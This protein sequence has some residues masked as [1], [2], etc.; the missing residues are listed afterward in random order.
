MKNS[1]SWI[2]IYKIY[3]NVRNS[4]NADTHI[5]GFMSREIK[6]STDGL[7][8]LFFCSVFHLVFR[9]G[10]LCAAGYA[11]FV[12]YAQSVFCLTR[13]NERWH[14]LYGRRVGVVF[15]RKNKQTV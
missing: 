13:A 2:N 15:V 11:L 12:S 4:A 9:G 7:S 8:V 14:M 10:F 5:A 3:R 1:L 6:K